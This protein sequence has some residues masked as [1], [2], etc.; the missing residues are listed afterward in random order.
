MS[1]ELLQVLTVATLATSAAIVLVLAL[2]RSMRRRF[3]A[4]AAYTLWSI[5]PFVA[6]V[7]LLPAPVGDAPLPF[8]AGAIAQVLQAPAVAGTSLAVRFDPDPWISLVWLFGVAAS[9]VILLRQQRRFISGLGRLVA[10]GDRLRA[11]TSSGGPALVGALR[12]RIVVPADFEARFSSVE[13]DLILEHERSH[14]RCGDAQV[15]LLAAALRCLFWFN[16]LV[17]F[18]ASRLRFDQEL[19]CDA[20]VIARFPEARRSYAGA[21]LK[22]QLADESRQEPG[23]PVGCYWQPSH[24][25]KERITMLKH[26]LPGAQR[27]TLGFVLAA[28]LIT[29]TTYAAWA[30]Q[31]AVPRAMPGAASTPGAALRAELVLSIDGVPLDAKWN[32]RADGYTSIRH[33]AATAPSRWQFG[34]SDG[35]AFSVAIDRNGESWKLAGIPQLKGDGTIELASVLS[36]NAAAVGSPRLLLRDG[37]AGGLRVGEEDAAGFKGFGAQITFARAGSVAKSGA[38]APQAAS[39]PAQRHAASYRSLTR[40]AYPPAPLAAGTEGVVYVAVRVGEDGKPASVALHHV[41]PAAAS[42]LAPAALAGVASWRFNPAEQDGKPVAS[43]EIV[44]IVFTREPSAWPSVSGGTL[45]GIR[46]S[47]PDEA[48]AQS[49]DRPVTEDVTYRQMHAPKYPPEAVRDHVVGELLFKVLVD[50]HGTPQSVDVEKS[51]P[52][53]AA[54]TLAATSIEAIMQWRFNPALKAG[55]PHAGYILVPITFALDDA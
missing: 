18:A 10:E 42:A 49:M 48:R 24:P 31:P 13:R 20:R 9:T 30:S 43:Q 53:E 36:H 14:R 7:G 3:G 50:E 33:D 8:E 45:D 16:P 11:A 12:P 35:Q 17:H 2:R 23:L 22:T 38:P 6:V 46:V 55:R 25:L 32:S 1:A 54:R 21:M 52:P 15:N 39:V 28:T 40:I 44:P 41:D 27:R 34:L 51:D 37:E 5:V 29:G 19:A 47:P 26:P 4:V